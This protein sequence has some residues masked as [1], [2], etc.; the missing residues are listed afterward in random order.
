MPDRVKLIW[1]VNRH[2]D[3]VHQAG[4]LDIQQPSIEGV[5]VCAAQLIRPVQQHPAQSLDLEPL[6]RSLD[7]A[8]KPS[9]NVTAG[10][11]NARDL[12]NDLP[13]RHTDLTELGFAI[14]VGNGCVEGIDAT[15]PGAVENI[16]GL[17]T[18]NLTC[19][20]GDTIREAKLDGAEGEA[21][22]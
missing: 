15:R 17:V 3:L 7:A 22:G 11:V 2:A 16:G 8:P 20:I 19:E 6:E 4:G 10:V 13:F 18:T 5:T 21:S 12:R 1:T 14:S 9:P